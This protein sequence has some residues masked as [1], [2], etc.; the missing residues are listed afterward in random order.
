MKQMP[1][2]GNRKRMQRQNAEIN[3]IVQIKSLLLSFLCWQ[4]KKI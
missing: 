3:A 2:Q 1:S 4:T